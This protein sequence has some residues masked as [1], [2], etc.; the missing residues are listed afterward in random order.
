MFETSYD[1]HLTRQELVQ[2]FFGRQ[3]VIYD[4]HREVAPT[5]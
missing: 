2:K 4:L 5:R 1:V 3:V